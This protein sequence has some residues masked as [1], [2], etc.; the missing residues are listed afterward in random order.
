MIGIEEFWLWLVL[1]LLLILILL[2]M[3]PPWAVR[4]LLEMIREREALEASLADM[5]VKLERVRVQ[6][7]QAQDKMAA[8]PEVLND[9]EDFDAWVTWLEKFE[10]AQERL[11]E[12]ERQMREAEARLRGE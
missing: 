10:E 4:R 5:R 1:L 8:F 6:M 2:T 7:A 12:I 3:L 9:P 11:R